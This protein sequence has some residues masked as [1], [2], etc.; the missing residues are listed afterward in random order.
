MSR[1]TAGRNACGVTRHMER[2]VAGHG[3]A[4]HVCAGAVGDV[5]TEWPESFAS[6]SSPA[7]EHDE[8]TAWSSRAAEPLSQKPRGRRRHGRCL[9]YKV[10]VTALGRAGAPPFGG[11]HS[12]A[13]KL[14]GVNVLIR[15]IFICS[16]VGACLYHKAILAFS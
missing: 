2:M 7:C 5:P 13:K 11:Q 14:F 9:R 1:V 16:Y 8:A 6:P 4:G 3:G 10:S 15:Q 12:G